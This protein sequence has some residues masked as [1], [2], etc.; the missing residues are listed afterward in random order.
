MNVS[1]PDVVQGVQ[2]LVDARLILEECE[3]IFYCEIE[4][5]GDGQSAKA[6][7]ESLAVVSLALADIARNVDVGKEMHLDL[8]KSISFAR[9]ASAALHIEREATRAVAADFRFGHFREEL[10]NWSEQPRV[11]R[12]VR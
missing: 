9:F 4:N 5:V 1:E 3:R 7:L 11:R 8:D 2:L 10:A 6:D 12:G